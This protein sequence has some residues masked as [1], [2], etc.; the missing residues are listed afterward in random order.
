MF[1]WLAAATSPPCNFMVNGHQYDQGYFLA[2]GIYPSQSTFVKSI[3]KSE[4]M[5]HKHF[6]KAKEVQRKGNERAFGVLQARFAICW[7]LARFWNK[8]VLQI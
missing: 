1:A 8:H 7:E 6:A 2:Y 3:S 5:K 4:S